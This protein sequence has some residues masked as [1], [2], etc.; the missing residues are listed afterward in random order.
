MIKDIKALWALLSLPNRKRLMAAVFLCVGSVLCGILPYAGLYEMVCCFLQN[1]LQALPLAVA[2]ISGAICARHVLFGAGTKLSHRVAYETLGETRKKLFEKIAKLPLGCVKTTASGQVKSIIM[3]DM[4]QLETFYAHNIP[5]IISGL[6]VPLCMELVL[7]CLDVRVA[8]IMM[9]PV[10]LFFIASGRMIAVQMKK[11][12]EFNAAFADVNTRTVEYINGMKELKLFSAD[13]KTYG[14]FADSIRRYHTVV[15]DWFRSSLKYIAF[16]HADL[17]SNLVFLFPLAGWMMLD[18]SIPAAGFILY[19]FMGLAMLAPLE[20]VSNNFD[21]IGMNASVAKRIS[22]LL[23][24][25]EMP[26]QGARQILQEHS[27]RFQNVDFSYEDGTQAL[28]QVSFVAEDGAV[29]ALV[30]ASGSGKSTI[31]SLISRFWDVD[32]GEI[33]LGGVP[34]AQLP[35]AELMENI[36]FVTQQPFLFKKSIRDN[37][38]MGNPKASEQDMVAA[39][40]AAVCHEFIMRLPHGYDTIIDEETQLSGGEKQRLTLARAILKDAPLIVLDEAT[41][42][43]DP[44]NEDLLQQALVQLAKDKTV[45]IIAHRLSI[46]EQADHIVVLEHGTVVDEGPHDV[47]IERCP[48]YQTMGEAFSQA[49]SWQMRGV[50]A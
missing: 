2:L 39:A 31:A 13:E 37:I 12:D 42:Y 49:D 9:I 40:K 38:L 26:D 43:I 6:A 29:T 5:E 50:R 8:A 18:D 36:A 32:D 14:H 19:L 23:S 22:A 41:A 33:F 20:T 30:G 34:L 46:V 47:L 15:T 25:P 3:D 16:N 35:L 10:V 7:V 24:L 45:V 44:E 28:K 4:E 21:Y 48:A 27:V 11:M 1:D 17:N